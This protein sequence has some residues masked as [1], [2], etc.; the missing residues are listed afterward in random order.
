MEVL[1]FGTVRFPD[2][3]TQDEI[4][5]VLRRKFPRPSVAMKTNDWGDVLV[6]PAAPVK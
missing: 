6:E 2:M 3:M 5:A 4:R 1:G